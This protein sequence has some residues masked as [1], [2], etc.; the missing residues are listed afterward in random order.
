MIKQLVDR[1]FHWI[2][3]GNEEEEPPETF[4]HM[5]WRHI[6]RETQKGEK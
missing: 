3:F 4:E 1:F 6:I 2:I 5:K